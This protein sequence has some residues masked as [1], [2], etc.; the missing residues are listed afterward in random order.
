MCAS[1]LTEA[2]L[3]EVF[4]TLCTARMRSSFWREASGPEGALGIMVQKILEFR[5]GLGPEYKL[6][7]ESIAHLLSEGVHSNTA[8]GSGSAPRPVHLG[9]F[10]KGRPSGGSGLWARRSARI[11]KIAVWG[12]AQTEELTSQQFILGDRV[13]S[14]FLKQGNAAEL[15]QDISWYFHPKWQYWDHPANVE[16]AVAEVYGLMSRRRL[17]QHQQVSSIIRISNRL[18]FPQVSRDC[19]NLEPSGD[20][21]IEAIKAGIWCYFVFP[22]AGERP[23]QAKVSAKAFRSLAIAK[24]DLS[25]EEIGRIVLHEV[26]PSNINEMFNS[27]S[28]NFF[29]P[30]LRWTI[31]SHN[32]QM[33]PSVLL[34][35]GSDCN[36]PHLFLTERESLQVLDWVKQL[37][38]NDSAFLASSEG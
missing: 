22:Y 30:F 16:E 23:S 29:V 5:K 27:G 2:N 35:R 13:K 33:A 34:Q 31:Y 3:E 21:T 8:D 19:Q 18:R 26:R 15:L 37:M 7:N 11:L 12:S 1:P 20:A 38:P 4:C 25:R 14:F 10:F 9:K 24:G 36:P 28:M 6:T 32:A 17:Q